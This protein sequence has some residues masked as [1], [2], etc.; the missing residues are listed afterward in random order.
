MMQAIAET[1]IY[2]DKFFIIYALTTFNKTVG[3]LRRS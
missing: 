2:F 1:T 3:T